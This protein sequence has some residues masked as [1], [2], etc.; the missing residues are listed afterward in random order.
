MHAGIHGQEAARHNSKVTKRHF[1]QGANLWAKDRWNPA[2]GVGRGGG[3]PGIESE[4]ITAACC[5]PALPK[6]SGLAMQLRVC[7]TGPG[8]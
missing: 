5:C 7:F 3:N 4:L 6:P 2:Q 8:E 1:C